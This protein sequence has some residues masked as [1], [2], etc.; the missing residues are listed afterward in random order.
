MDRAFRFLARFKKAL[1]AKLQFME[2]A[3]ASA[4]QKPGSGNAN[5]KRFLGFDIPYLLAEWKEALN[6]KTMPSD[7][8]SGITVALVALPLNLA[9]AIAAG[10]EPGVG[11]T[12]GIVAGIVG[13]LFGGQ[14]YAVTGPA[15]AM[16]VVLIEIAQ[17]HGIAAVWLVGL[18]SGILQLIA[19]ACRLGKLI[20]FI[21]MP[22][23]V[24]FANAIGVLVIF[25]SLDDFLGI[26][27]KR[28]AHAGAAPP[29]Q[30]HPFVPEFIQ[31]IISLFWH[32][33]VHQQWSIY[34]LSIG[35]LV[36]TIAVLV[37]RWTKAVPGQL[38]AV[39]V[40]S[41]VAALLSFNIPRIIDIAS[42]PT[43]LPFPTIPQ[44]P[45][46]NFETLFAST[47]TVFMLGSIE[48]LLSAS[49]ADGMTMSRRHH[50]DQELMGQGLANVI[51]PFFGGI[52]VTGVIARTAVNIR[53]GA[54]TRLSGIVHSLFLMLLTFALAK[55]AEQIPLAALSA[56]LVL[57]GFRLI[58]AD[59]TRQIWKA[60]KTEGMV[61]LV[62]TAVSVLVDLTAGVVTGLLLTT[63]LFI[64][65]MSEVK[66][67][68]Q[69]YDPDRRSLVRQ[70][71]PTCKFVRTYLV[72][73]PLF[74]GAAERFTETILLV[75]NLKAVILNMKT[76]GVM[77]LTGAETVQSIYE[78]LKRNGIRLI[79]SDLAHQPFELL[80]RTGAIE[81]IGRQNFFR[82]YKDAILSAN[83]ELLKTSCQGCAAVLNNGEKP[84]TGAVK[85]C[86]LRNAM[87]LNTNQIANV[88]RTCMGDPCMPPVV[89]DNKT[90]LEIER[91]IALDSRDDIPE[92]LRGT[93][94]EDI[95]SSHNFYEV[96]EIDV[97]HEPELIIGMCVDYR[98]Q[99]H[100][101][102]NTA[103]IIRSPGA[104][105][106]DCEF[107]IALGLAKGLKYMALVVHNNCSMTD[108]FADRQGL[109]DSLSKEHGWNQAQAEKFFD[110]LADEKAIDN[111]IDFGLEEAQRLRNL[112]KGLTVVPMLYNVDND[113]LYLL[114]DPEQDNAAAPELLEQENIVS[115]SLVQD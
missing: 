25:N 17:N 91:L 23:I 99:L 70:P 11:I 69:D 113:R 109:V 27:T 82:K 59:A 2:N 65:Q 52:P 78:Q 67:V 66:I 60:S 63:G 61:T 74:F 10:V 37:P 34:A 102:N 107:A 80:K 105:M 97:E 26:P 101:P 53:A 5:T 16:A 28:I 22:V 85:D 14:K 42:I 56:V 18:L 90:E 103:Y 3:A 47:I 68:E 50:S 64:K 96:S 87:I 93:P 95:I 6:L 43:T 48:S 1:L 108:P 39:V 32:T 30:G 81:K 94:V 44:L 111:P 112:F 88:M 62:T 106:H 115:H 72:D 33:V 86:T 51:V 12:T 35:L 104:N 7:I 84:A 36:F 76:V 21:P 54:K 75:Q 9:L 79:L 4:D 100:L 83:S 40:G 38:V 71:I 45:F 13:S 92:Y 46:D 19:G 8:W 41:V 73:G 20:S 15:A 57:T 110:R 98:R 29:L 55:Y 31:D 24:G 49:V 58:E 89:E 77:D 114:K